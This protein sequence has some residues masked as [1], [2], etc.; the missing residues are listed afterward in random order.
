MTGER[1]P[2]VKVLDL[3]SGGH[4]VIRSLVEEGIDYTAVEIR[5]ENVDSISSELSH[6]PN[7][8]VVKG[9]ATRLDQ[10]HLDK[11][12][13][14]LIAGL[15]YHLDPLDHLK[16][17]AKALALAGRG[18]IVD[19]VFADE[20]AGQHCYFELDGYIYEGRAFCEHQEIDSASLIRSRIRS[21]FQEEGQRHLSFVAT[22][23]SFVRLLRKHG[24]K[25]V[26]RYK[27]SPGVNEAP[28]RP[29][30]T[31]DGTRPWTALMNSERGILAAYLH[32]GLTGQ[33]ASPGYF[34]FPRGEGK[35]GDLAPEQLELAKGRLCS[36]I[37][38]DSK[39]GSDVFE[40]IHSA[41]R[42]LPL[43]LHRIIVEAGIEAGMGLSDLVGLRIYAE[44]YLKSANPDREKEVDRFISSYLAH[45]SSL[46]REW[47]QSMA[48]TFRSYLINYL[49]PL[50]RRNTL[51]RVGRTRFGKLARTLGRR[52]A[53]GRDKRT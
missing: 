10:L 19:T 32:P 1:Y 43:S 20:K 23:D 52:G 38:E 50:A 9:D 30:K 47:A 45:L 14:V 35:F 18:I 3:A 41:G 39:S 13:V 24:C 53:A 34:Q 46:D 31:G 28:T 40:T 7:A 5:D 8:R 33:E 51:E 26:S 12:D 42:M 25:M 11:F 29:P 17:L 22:E 2:D 21:S 48:T 6:L 16:V 4:C 49:P 44:S 37:L 15:F 36:L 27:Y